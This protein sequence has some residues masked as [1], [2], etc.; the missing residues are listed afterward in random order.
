MNKNS[1]FFDRFSISQSRYYML[2]SLDN[3]Y[4]VLRSH[5]SK[6]SVNSKS[7]DLLYQDVHDCNTV[8]ALLTD[9]CFSIISGK[10]DLVINDVIAIK[11]NGQLFCYR[12][13]S[14]IKSLLQFNAAKSFSY[15]PVFFQSEIEGYISI[16]HNENKVLSVLDGRVFSLYDECLCNSHVYCIESNITSKHYNSLLFYFYIYYFHNMS[17]DT[18]N[19]AGV[20]FTTLNNAFYYYK[21]KC[22]NT[23]PSILLFNLYELEMIKDYYELKCL[24][25]IG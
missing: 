3:L 23:I 10:I 8:N 1:L 9:L 4:G 19:P 11:I 12:Y 20:P 18:V 7:Y 5:N 25:K 21:K 14:E 15:I 17:I 6:Q 24:S 22:K 2:F 16:L 13:V